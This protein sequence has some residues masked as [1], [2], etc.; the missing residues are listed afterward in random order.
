MSRSN[1]LPG[2]V[3][4]RDR[5]SRGRA[6]AA[7]RRGSSVARSAASGRPL[8]DAH[9]SICTATSLSGNRSRTQLPTRVM[10][11]SPWVESC[12]SGIGKLVAEP[13]PTTLIVVNIRTTDSAGR[14][15][16][17][18]REENCRGSS[19]TNLPICLQPM[20][21]NTSQDAIYGHPKIIMEPTGIVFLNDKDAA[22]IT[23]PR[24]PDRFARFRKNSVASI[25]CER[26]CFAFDCL[27]V[28]STRLGISLIANQPSRTTSSGLLS[29]HK[30]GIEGVA[31]CIPPSTR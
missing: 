16:G 18:N 1:L 22:A 12:A 14:D 15:P 30:R 31:A 4:R 28:S 8:Y 17:P 7:R 10:P 2:V 24:S 6:P 25:C 26:H 19:R 29:S 9:S 13:I 20:L 23:S 5:L 3:T 21:A 27:G 11:R